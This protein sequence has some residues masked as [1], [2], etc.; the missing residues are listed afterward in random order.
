MKNKIIKTLAKAKTNFKNMSKEIYNFEKE[1][2]FDKTSSTQLIKW[3]KEEI[4]N[5][6]KAKSKV[7]KQNKLMDI[8]CLAIQISRRENID[9]DVA[10]VKRW[11]KSK[12]Y[13]EKR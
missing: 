13:L 9:L 10:W 5:Y 6:K 1:A 7:I 8:I 12:K 2:R 4:E 3:L 11:E